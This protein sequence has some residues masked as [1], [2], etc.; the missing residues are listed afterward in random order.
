MV[1]K[2]PGASHWARG[3]ETKPTQPGDKTQTPEW[4]KLAKVFLQWVLLRW[5]EQVLQA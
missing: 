2:K 1:D 5:G 3:T 4:S